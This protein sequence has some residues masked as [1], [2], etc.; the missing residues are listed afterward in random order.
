MGTRIKLNALNFYQNKIYSMY[1]AWIK[2]PTVATWILRLHE[3]VEPVN[4]QL[5]TPASADVTLRI[6]RVT[7]PLTQVTFTLEVKA[8]VT[9]TSP[10][11]GSMVAVTE[12]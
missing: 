11:K 6:I 9:E 4:S 12:L 5:Y 3:F 7:F 10:V 1:N 8:G 2:L